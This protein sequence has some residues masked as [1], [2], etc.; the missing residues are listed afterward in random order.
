L[1]LEGDGRVQ[2]VVVPDRPPIDCDLVV[3]AIGI[4]P[5]KDLVRGTAIKAEHA[6]LVDS[7]CLTSEPDIYAAGDCAAIFDPLFGKYRLLDHWDS[8]TTMGRIAGLNI[9]GQTTEYNEVNSFSTRAMGI[10][11]KVWGAP[12]SV[13]RG[14]VRG[15]VQTHEPDFIE[16]G[17]SDD[18]R[19]AQI[20]AVN[21]ATED[22]LLHK[23]VATR[24]GVTGKE[25]Q[26]RDPAIPLQQLL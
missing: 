17:I 23:L 19:V 14:I 7:R 25:T 1:R 10:E 9:A 8:A 26:L 24:L 22:D 3:A 16:I 20:V 5:N 21:H 12:R 4:A 2:R 18:D 13:T 11:V 6:I 15:S